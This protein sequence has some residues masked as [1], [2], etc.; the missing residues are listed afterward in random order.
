MGYLKP[1]NIA[2]EDSETPWLTTQAMEFIAQAEEPWCAHLSYIKPHWPYIVPAPYH[3]MYGPEHVLP[4][5][6]SEA[7]RESAHPVFDGQRKSYRT[8]RT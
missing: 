2:E 4:V 3:D 8:D 6:H 5:V 1:A 7:E